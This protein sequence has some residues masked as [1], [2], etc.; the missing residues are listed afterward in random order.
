MA[1]KGTVPIAPDKKSPIRPPT[2]VVN[3]NKPVAPDKKDPIKPSTFTPIAQDKFDWLKYAQEKGFSKKWGRDP[4]NDKDGVL[5]QDYLKNNPDWGSKTPDKPLDPTKPKPKPDPTK[6]GTTKV[7]AGVPDPKDPSQMN[8][9]DWASQVVSNPSLAFTQ[10]NPKTPQNESMSVSDR[11]KD[12]VIDPTKGGL[13]DPNDPKL[14][15]TNVADVKSQNV[16][17]QKPTD[18]EGYDVKTTL[19]DVK[20]NQMTGAKGELSDGSTVDPNVGQVDMKGMAT[21]VNA[22]GS[23]NYAGQA[24]Q[25]FA[26]QNMSNII[27]TSTSAGKALAE[28]LGEGNYLDSKA[29]LKGQLD[30]LQSEF[31]GPNG[32]PKIPLWAQG[33][34]R[35]VS[36]IAAFGGMTGTA[37]TAAMANAIMEASIPVAQADSQF[38]QT[39]TLKNLD[40]KQ[41]SILNTANVLS[42]MEQTNADNRLAAA[43]NNS[44]AF[45]EMD[46]AN[47]SNEQ[48]AKVINNQARIQSILEDAKAVNA[49]RLFEADSQNDK[50]KFYAQLNTQI[51]QFNSSQNLDAQK[52][53]QTMEDSRDKFYKE[54]QYNIAISNAKWRQSVQLQEDTQAHEAATQD[55]K[56]MTDMS[57]NQLNQIWD[58]SDALLD[59][60]WKSSESSKDRDTQLALAKLKAKSDSKNA[61]TT[62]IGQLVGSFVG[63]D[64]GGKVLGDIFGF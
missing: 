62:A 17:Q 57:I 7:V 53:N 23:I 8:I 56:N 39:L 9:G 33:A 43:I 29:T 3:P 49:E 21:G 25:K 15:Q 30:I 1:K 19:G 11:A 41:Q 16:A 4:N 35:N 18:A 13:V 37:A 51:S 10:D 28:Q 58:R 6:P 24:L 32:E 45:L 64:A 44:K 31:V 52:F 63:S 38:F 55:V 50:D 61:N 42:K 36:K 54:M 12:N 27:D 5:Y 47:L 34:A 59:Y 14:K 46:M 48:Q 20:K 2:T 60:I 40:N 22:D 26:T